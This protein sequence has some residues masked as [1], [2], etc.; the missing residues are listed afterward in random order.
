MSGSGGSA[1]FFDVRMRGFRDRADVDEVVR[2]LSA[3]IQPL[4]PEALNINDAAGRVLAED[5][6]SDVD[7]PA[8]ERAAMDGYAL[9]AQQTSSEAASS[10]AG[11]FREAGR[12]EAEHGHLA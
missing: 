5:L 1:S 4:P 2:F 9:H 8:F 11:L 12:I 3:R 7:V 6:T 10:M